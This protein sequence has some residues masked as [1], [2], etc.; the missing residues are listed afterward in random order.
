M[1]PTSRYSIITPSYNQRQYLEG[2]LDSVAAQDYPAFE[3]VVIDGE[4]SDGSVE[5]LE[6]YG[7]EYDHLCFVSE[8]D[9]GQ[10]DAINKG[11]DLATGDIVGWL[12]ADDV[13]F[14]RSVLSRVAS[15]FDVTGADAVYGDI[16]LINADSDVLKLQ[17]APGFDYNKLLRYCFIDQPALFLDANCLEGERLDTD[18]E[19][20]MDYEFWL[21]LARDY[22]FL[23][24]DDVLAGDRNHPNR[25]ILR[26][27]KEMLVESEHVSKTYGR[28]VG[29]SYRLGRL[30]D[31]LTSGVP[32]RLVAASRTVQMHRS[33]P[34]LA[35]EGGFRPLREMLWNVFRPSRSLI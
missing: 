15:A 27:R 30:R 5:L 31:A 21:R 23:H 2:T 9:D 32:R 29:T 34:S 7:A 13:Y 20:A 12:N 28:P 24:I 6:R 14:H 35:F 19:Y 33:P 22:E 25:K 16:A 11:F 18:L 3:H 10:A 26:D 4:S 1:G 8:P 17:L